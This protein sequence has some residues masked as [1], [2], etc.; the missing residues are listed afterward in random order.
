M[1]TFVFVQFCSQSCRKGIS[2]SPH[3]VCYQWV[4]HVVCHRKSPTRVLWQWTEMEYPD[5]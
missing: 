3:V 1:G 2:V 4:F 5:V